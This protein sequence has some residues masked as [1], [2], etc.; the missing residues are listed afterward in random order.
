MVVIAPADVL[1]RKRPR[2]RVRQ[3]DLM[4]IAR[5]RMSRD[6]VRK[7]QILEIAPDLAVEIRSPGDT[8]ARWAEKLADYASIGVAEVWRIDPDS[9]TVEVLTLVGGTYQAAGRFGEDDT[10][11][12]G[13]LPG[14]ALGVRAIFA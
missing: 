1:I 4:F 14:L 12:P 3:P 10:V 2:L 5:E 8:A 13:V 7:V 11:Q 9:R 6:E